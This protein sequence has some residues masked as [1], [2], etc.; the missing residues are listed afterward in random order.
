MKNPRGWQNSRRRGG[1]GRAIADLGYEFLIALAAVDEVTPHRGA[2]RGCGAGADGVEDFHVLVLDALE[3]S[4][5]ILERR[6]SLANALAR[7][8]ETAEI[9]EKTLELRIAGG[10][11]DAAKERKVLIDSRLAP[12]PGILDA[13]ETLGDPFDVPRHCGA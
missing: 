6:E 1:G 9:V 8:D 2:R 5:L 3:V 10:L 4:A 11:G 13:P 7:N 12:P